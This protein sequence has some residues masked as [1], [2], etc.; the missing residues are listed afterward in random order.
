MVKKISPLAPKSFPKVPDIKGVK[1]GTAK[2]GVKYKGR[3]DIFTAIFDKGTSVAGV[4]TQS[5]IPAEPVNFCKKNIVDGKAKALVVNAGFANAFTGV[6]GK[7]INKSISSNV[8]KILK[9]NEKDIFICSTGVIG[10]Q[11]PL[12]PTNKSITQSLR[13][14]SSNWKDCS[15][16]ITTTDTFPKASGRK[17]MIDDQEVSL[18]GIAKGSGMISPNMA[19]MLAFIFTDAAIDNRVLQT[20]LNLE[21]RNSFN[22]I[23]VD[24]DTSTND[25]VLVFATG[26][27][28]KENSGK[29]ISRTGDPRLIQFREAFSEIMHDLAIQIVRDGEGATK[30]IHIKV[31]GAENSSSAKKIARSVA[32]SPLVKTAIGASDPNWGRI[33]MAIGKTKEIIQ[34]KKINLK[35]GKNLILKNGEVSRSYSESRTKKYMDGN[36]ILID[37]NLGLGKG[38]SDIWTCDLT[39]GYI[40]INADYR[41]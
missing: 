27:A 15:K 10:E 8:K 28:M 17:I 1:I 3:N 16:A 39:E 33:I 32:D 9:C 13:N 25:T 18:A 23:T 36:E 35:I 38:E 11:I 22:A 21:L 31:S 40:R 24:G 19:T 34:P 37:I 5:K 6:K 14:S 12:R 29:V 4:F 20:L 2:S 7:K 26:Q 41:S 30:L